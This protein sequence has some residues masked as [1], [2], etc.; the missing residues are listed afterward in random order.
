[1]NKS[2][3]IPTSSSNAEFSEQAQEFIEN[4]IKEK[5]NNNENNTKKTGKNV[6][7]QHLYHFNL[8]LRHG[9]RILRYEAK[10]FEYY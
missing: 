2:E 8:L 3:V 9:G 1:M 6:I 5:T 7:K 10:K 4:T